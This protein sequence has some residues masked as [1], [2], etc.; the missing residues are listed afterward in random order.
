MEI[1]LSDQWKAVCGSNWSSLEAQVVCEQLG[2]AH[3]G[4]IYIHAFM[5]CGSVLTVRVYTVYISSTGAV[6]LT[7]AAFGQGLGM[8]VED[9]R[10]NGTE[11]RLID[12]SIRDVPDGQ[13]SRNEDA[14]V[15]CCEFSQHLGNNQCSHIVIYTM[16]CIHV[17]FNFSCNMSDW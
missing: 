8:I 13:C 11:R 15:R 1:C 16:A 4:A 14:G 5:L 17:S 10:C 9:V 3:Q 12:C 7:Q 6:P 2:Y